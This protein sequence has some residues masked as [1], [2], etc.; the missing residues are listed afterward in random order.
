[1][2]CVDQEAR[3]MALQALNQISLLKAVSNE[4]DK[5]IMADLTVI[6]RILAWGTAGL[7][8]SMATLIYWLISHPHL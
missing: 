2:T 5:S 7:I 3:N 1:M 8:G 4:R 6:K